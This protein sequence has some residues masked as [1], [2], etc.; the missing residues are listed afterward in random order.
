MPQTTTTEAVTA[1]ELA[2]KHADKPS[3]QEVKQREIDK[4]IHQINVIRSQNIPPVEAED[5]T[6][7]DEAAEEYYALNSRKRLHR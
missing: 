5:E 7:F 2:T 4:L 1:D 6:A 3:G